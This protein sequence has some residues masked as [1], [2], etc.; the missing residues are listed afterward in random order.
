M[1]S[2]D[3]TLISASA[4]PNCGVKLKGTVLPSIREVAQV[5]GQLVACFQAVTLGPLNYR[6]LRMEKPKALKEV[7][8]TIE[9]KMTLSN[10]AH[11]DV[12]W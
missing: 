3:G 8:G 11:Q 4:A 5:T 2:P 7:A 6:H 10:E 9:A 1:F 12:N